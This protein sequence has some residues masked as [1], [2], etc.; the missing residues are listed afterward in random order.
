M[1]LLLSLGFSIH[2]TSLEC[3]VHSCNERTRNKFLQSAIILEWFQVGIVVVIN[4]FLLVNALESKNCWSRQ[5]RNQWGIKP[6]QDI[7]QNSLGRVQRGWNFSSGYG[8]LSSVR[9]QDHIGI[10]FC[11]KLI[12]QEIVQCLLFCQY[13]CDNSSFSFCTRYQIAR[14]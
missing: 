3:C 11:F 4:T 1:K 10:Q 8:F 5:M 13:V 6:Y 9:Y 12:T 14:S 2:W 7:M